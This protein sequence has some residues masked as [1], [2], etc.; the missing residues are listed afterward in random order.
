[1][2]RLAAFARRTD[3]ATLGDFAAMVAILFALG[4]FAI[5][6]HTEKTFADSMDVLTPPGAE[7]FHHTEPVGNDVP[8][9]IH[10]SGVPQQ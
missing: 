6:G 3:G 7:G 5:L 9:A 2:N 1:M 10:I 4:T 8:T